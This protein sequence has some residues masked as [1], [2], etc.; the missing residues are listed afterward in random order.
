MKRLLSFLFV[1]FMVSP[2]SSQTMHNLVGIW[3]ATGI[4]DS[5]KCNS[6]L[7]FDQ[8]GKFRYLSLDSA[9]FVDKKGTWEISAT[10]RITI[11]IRT[12][13]TTKQI[14]FFRTLE[15]KY[16]FMLDKTKSS[17]LFDNRIF[18]KIEG[19]FS[20]PTPTPTK[21]TD[22]SPQKVLVKKKGIVI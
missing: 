10:H 19:E 6:V 3:E 20:T 5:L 12:L 7:H 2:S 17:G 21:E 13:K 16:S 11:V 18:K 14:I 9:D 22:K 15:E 8:S 1:L 4:N